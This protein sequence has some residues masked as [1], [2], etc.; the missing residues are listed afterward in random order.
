[1]A[2][3]NVRGTQVLDASIQRRDCDVSTVGQS[4][5]VKVL[6][7]TGIS[8]SATGGDA[9]TGD[10][11][12]SMSSSIAS[13]VEVT[14]TAQTAAID[15]GY[16]L[17]NVALVT[18]TLPTT[19]AVGDVVAVV[20]KGAGGWKVAQNASQVINFVDL[21]TTTGTG[22]SLAST[23]RYDCVELVCIVANTTWVVRSSEGNI[24]VV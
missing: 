23:Q 15:T 14:G 10:A 9:G 12:I 1:M 5:L 4:V 6:P 19:A 22:G 11:T 8:I 16:I 21:A 3:T 17:N 20:G 13:W 18:L 24:T 7:G 2:V